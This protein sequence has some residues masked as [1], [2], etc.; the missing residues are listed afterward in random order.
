MGIYGVAGAYGNDIRFFAI[1]AVMRV[2]F[3]TIILTCLE[4]E[5]GTAVGYE[6]TVAVLASLAALT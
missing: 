1:T 3:G 5:K 6:F 4:M 2:L